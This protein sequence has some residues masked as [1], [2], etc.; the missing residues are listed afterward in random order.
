[1]R[2][3]YSNY[4]NDFCNTYG[5]SGAQVA[6]MVGMAEE[7]I[8][9]IRRG[10][11]KPQQATKDKLNRFILNYK[12]ENQPMTPITSQETQIDIVGIDSRTV[13][14]WTGKEHKSLMRDI[15]QYT[16]FLKGTD[17]CSTDF[18]QETTYT[19]SNGKENPCYMITK[20]GCEFIQHKMT[21]QKGA[22]FTAKY[23]NYFWE[24]GEQLQE[25]TQILL[26][27]SDQ[28]TQPAIELNSDMA[29]I[30]SR[31]A[32]MQN[33]TTMADIKVGLAKTYRIAELMED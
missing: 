14:E 18:W 21:G 32:E 17:L 16:E 7:T 6:R 27:L 26:D 29:Y 19:A 23:I 31:L 30:K 33:M 28:P 15:R 5:L 10:E 8:Q 12:K 9:A 25:A 20:K 11:R 22:V 3:N 1:M 2:R 24:Q 4:L 13:A